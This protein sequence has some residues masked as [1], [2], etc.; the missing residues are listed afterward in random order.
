MRHPRLATG[1]LARAAVAGVAVAG[2]AVVS[3]APAKGGNSDNVVVCFNKAG[4]NGFPKPVYRTTPGRC[5]FV[6]KGGQPISAN[7]VTTKKLNWKSWGNGHARAKGRE[8]IS[9]AGPVR[10][11]VRLSRARH[12]CGNTVFTRAQFT[13]PKS[14]LSTTLPLDPCTH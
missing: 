13:S 9:T 6:H 11:V 14:G 12:R 4:N 3:Q 5:M 7:S 8:L 1:I 10:V 2:F